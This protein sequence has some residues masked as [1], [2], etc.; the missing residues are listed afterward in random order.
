MA[1]NSAISISFRVA[2]GENGLKKLTV[3]AKEL[4]KVMQAT[5]GIS[6]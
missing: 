4:H 5:V 6:T 3:N 1:S 2:D